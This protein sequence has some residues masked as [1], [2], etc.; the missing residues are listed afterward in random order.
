[1]AR[2]ASDPDLG[3]VLNEIHR[4]QRLTEGS[5]LAQK[6]ALLDPGHVLTFPHGLATVRMSIPDCQTD[7]IQSRILWHRDFFEA[8]VLSA[9]LDRGILR[10]GQIIWDVGA[11]IG[12]HT[13]FFALISGAKRVLSVEPLPHCFAVLDRNRSLNALEGRVQPIQALAGA[14]SGHGEL[15]AFNSANIGGSRFRS[16]P[17]G[18]VQLVALDEVAGHLPPDF[19]KIDVE[20]MQM[21]VLRG[22]ERMLTTHHPPVWI[23]LLTEAEHREATAWLTDRGYRQPEVLSHHNLLFLPEAG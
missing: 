6:A 18:D 9:L 1:M 19:V 8:N 4:L 5:A 10:K 14:A 11:N 15:I 2:A 13:V 3:D 23:E 22:A 7:L 21:D 17:D 12:N 20:G 16:N